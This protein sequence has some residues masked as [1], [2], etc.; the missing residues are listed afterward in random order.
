[1]IEAS[2]VIAHCQTR[3]DPLFAGISKTRTAV[4]DFR[5]ASLRWKATEPDLGH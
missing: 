4:N 3:Q 5:V 1:M 2:N